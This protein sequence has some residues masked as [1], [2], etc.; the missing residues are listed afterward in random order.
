MALPEQIIHAYKTILQE[1]LLVAM[2]CTEPISIAYAA[3]IVR[4]SLGAYPERMMA[5]LSG[6]IIAVFVQNA[7]GDRRS[8]FLRESNTREQQSQDQQQGCKLFHHFLLLDGHW[9]FTH[10]YPHFAPFCEPSRF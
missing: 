2:G 1:E 5:E 6:N 8:N 10:F 4:R 9:P 3:A 7:Q